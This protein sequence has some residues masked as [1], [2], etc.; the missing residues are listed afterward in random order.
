MPVRQLNLRGAA[1]PSAANFL[2]SSGDSLA[3]PPPCRTPKLSPNDR[4]CTAAAAA[5]C[6]LAH[7][8]VRRG[9]SCCGPWCHG[10]PASPLR[11]RGRRPSAAPTRRRRPGVPCDGGRF[12]APA[13]ARYA[14]ASSPGRRG[15]AS[16]MRE[17]RTE[18]RR[19][20]APRDTPRRFSSAGSLAP[21]ERWVS[22]GR[23]GGGGGGA[24]CAIGA[25]DHHANAYGPTPG[26]CLKGG[27]RAI[28]K[29]TKLHFKS[30]TAGRR[31]A[32]CVGV[33]AAIWWWGLNPR[34]R[35]PRRSRV[36]PPLPTRLGGASCNNCCT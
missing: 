35:P 33:G 11:S 9:S 2:V 30:P 36:C 5:L 27:P 18:R 17:M 15:A 4:F 22:C 12:S 28:K 1:H 8:V 26:T 31:H 14:S 20:R 23:G 3:L 16:A 34:C 6:R 10:A 29:R 24:D 7:R 32:L 13:G 21:V 25:C 19:A